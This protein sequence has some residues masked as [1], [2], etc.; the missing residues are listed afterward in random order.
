VRRRVVVDGG[1]PATKRNLR[2]LPAAVVAAAVVLPS[3]YY[4]FAAKRTLLPRRPQHC[5][6]AA[7]PSGTV[8]AWSPEAAAAA[9]VP[10]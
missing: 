2:Q 3:S 4:D 8:V 1:Q 6:R 5:R 9:P 10:F 7:A